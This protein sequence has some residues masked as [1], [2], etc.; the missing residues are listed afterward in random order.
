MGTGTATAKFTSTCS[1]A[2]LSVLLFCQL[3]CATLLVPQ[4][5]D[6]DSS[7]SLPHCPVASWCS[8]CCIEL[9]HSCLTCQLPIFPPPFWTIGHAIQVFAHPPPFPSNST[10]SS[11]PTFRP[12]LHALK[13]PASDQPETPHRRIS[14]QSEHQAWSLQTK[15]LLNPGKIPAS[16]TENGRRNTHLQHG[17]GMA[18]LLQTSW[19][20]LFAPHRPFSG[21]RVE[22][23]GCCRY[24]HNPPPTSSISETA[25]K[26]SWTGGTSFDELLWKLHGATIMAD[27]F[28]SFLARH[29]PS[30]RHIHPSKPRLRR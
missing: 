18:S 28:S 21:T 29:W 20:V 17:R 8:S 7:T 12:R 5:A 30:L 27:E 26:G 9:E 19:Q 1:P 25:N 13:L 10:S 15:I 22:S 11:I 23:T 3:R 2:A 24:I 16:T 14:R 6:A 4:S